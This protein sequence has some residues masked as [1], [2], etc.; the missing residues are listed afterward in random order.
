MSDLVRVEAP[1]AQTRPRGPRH[2]LDYAEPAAYV[3]VGALALA[4]LL[5]GQTRT[6]ANRTSTPVRRRRRWRWR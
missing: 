4:A 2:L 1:P 6:S 5:G 3:L